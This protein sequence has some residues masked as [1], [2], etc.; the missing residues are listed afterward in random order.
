M[1]TTDTAQPTAEQQLARDVTLATRRLWFGVAV[2]FIIALGGFASTY[3]PAYHFVVE[4]AE[5][6]R[7]D[8]SV[9]EPIYVN[10]TLSTFEI[11]R[12]TQAAGSYAPPPGAAP[13]PSM[14][15]GVPSAHPTL[16]AAVVV[17]ALGVALRFSVVQL[18]ALPLVV[19]AMRHMGEF[20]LFVEDPTGNGGFIQGPLLGV[21]LFTMATVALITV[22]LIAVVQTFIVNQRERAFRKEKAK[23]EGKRP[24]GTTLDLLGSIVSSYLNR[25]TKVPEPLDDDED[26]DDDARQR[27]NA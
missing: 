11:A 12:L 14:F 17:F 16:L 20:R 24:E 15:G 22:V 27:Q 1:S 7:S 10:E 21:T 23:A 4:G 9:S 5:I 2:A 8:M 19:R 6:V 3:V 25:F 18:A 26:A 13:L